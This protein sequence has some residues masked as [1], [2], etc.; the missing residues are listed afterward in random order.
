MNTSFD[1]MVK[2]KHF[3]LFLILVPNFANAKLFQNSYVK[4]ELPENWQCNMEQT[5]WICK[6]S[7][8][9]ASRE[10]VI[11]LTAKEVGPLDTLM[12]YETYLK[13]PKVAVDAKGQSLSA[14]IKQVQRRTVKN[15]E[16]IDG[17]VLGSEIP[18]FYTRYLATTKSKI[19]V[20]VTFT[21]HQRFYTKY[22]RDF[23]NAISSLEVLAS[24]ALLNQRSLAPLGTDSSLLGYNVGGVI[25]A[26][27]LAEAECLDG[28]DCGNS[29][30]GDDMGDMILALV[31]LILAVGGYL[32]LR[33]KK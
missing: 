26:D 9:N 16:W 2:M 18:N 30:G 11:I 15:H 24:D 20:L 21:A 14:Q 1:T 25:P 32:V 5:E 17:L 29:S 33:K 22:S 10:A 27:M 31:V 13:K 23:F 4:F 3:L 19:A 12:E 8:K 28:E 7:D 6:S